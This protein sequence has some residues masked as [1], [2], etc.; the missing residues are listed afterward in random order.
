MADEAGQPEPAAELEHALPGEPRRPL[1][2]RQQ[3][4]GGVHGRVPQQRAR[5]GAV[6][7]DVALDAV[8]R[9]RIPQRVWRHQVRRVR[10]HG[11][12]ARLAV[13]QPQRDLGDVSP[14]RGADPLRVYAAFGRIALLVP[15]VELLKIFWLYHPDIEVRRGVRPLPEQPIEDW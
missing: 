7:V 11:Q 9:L 5:P 4:L 10:K 6:L 1:G 13:R 2:R 12:H 3:P 15:E 8:A 14:F